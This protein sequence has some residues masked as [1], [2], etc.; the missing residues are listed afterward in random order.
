MEIANQEPENEIAGAVPAPIQIDPFP[1]PNDPPWNIPAAI[2]TW[3]ASVVFIVIFPNL[4]LLPYLASKQV[5]L[6]DKTKLLEFLLSDPTAIII[7]VL[8]IIPAHILTLAVAWMVVTRFKKFS[9]RETLGWK[10]GTMA[11]WYY[12]LLLFG[13]L[14]IGWVIGSYFP[15]QEND[16]TRILKSSRTAVYLVAFLA[17][18]T[19]PIVEEVIYRG[20]LYSALQ[21]TFGMSFAVVLVTFLFAL[22]H[23]P[24]YWPSHSTIFLLTLL[25]LTLTLIRERTGN[26]LPCIIF[27]FI[28]NG[29][30]SLGLVLAPFL[31]KP[32]TQ[33]DTVS[34]ILRLFQ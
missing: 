12:P 3:I 24:Q 10:G 16:L 9:F 13:F 19:A 22:V 33:S 4:F 17:T 30:Q 6:S 29:I 8:A 14:A 31:E 7:N 1:T 11:W 23:V 18:F 26:L 27:H 15:E 28:F 32:E 21:R 34:A 25:S 2:G 20:I 5:H